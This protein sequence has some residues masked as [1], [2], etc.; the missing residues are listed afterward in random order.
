MEE[1]LSHSHKN[2]PW[3]TTR[4]RDLPFC[5]PSLFLLS[6]MEKEHSAQTVYEYMLSA[7]KHMHTSFS[8][9]LLIEMFFSVKQAR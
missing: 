4:H 2:E 6:Q 7:L 8:M 9:Y 5:Q 1:D 3:N